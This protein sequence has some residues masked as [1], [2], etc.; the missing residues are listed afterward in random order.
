FISLGLGRLAEGWALY[1]YRWAGAQGLVPRAYRQPR[2]NG[3]RLAGTLLVWGE[4]GLGDEIL[5][6]SMIP[7]LMQRTGSVTVE[8]EPRLVTLFGRSFPG[9]KVIPLDPALYDGPF[10]AQEPI[11][12]LGRHFR[13]NW[14]AFPKRERGYLVADDARARALRA[15]LDDG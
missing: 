8:V 10:A 13:P 3:E 1:E 12:S 6:A 4:Q 2:W 14:A 7:D 5:H 9:A 15:R 11:A